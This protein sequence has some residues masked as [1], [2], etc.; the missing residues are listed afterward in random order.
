MSPSE[1][2]GFSNNQPQLRAE[3]HCSNTIRPQVPRIIVWTDLVTCR[4]RPFGRSKGA[5]LSLILVHQGL[6]RS[7]RGG[8]EKKANK[9]K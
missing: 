7:R 9:Y 5:F 6:G 2:G 8:V 3:S 1:L 4:N